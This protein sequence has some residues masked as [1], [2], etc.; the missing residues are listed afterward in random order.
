[1]L[2]Y[3]T[4]YVM[5]L[6]K[7]VFIMNKRV[8]LNLQFACTD[9]YGMPSKNKIKLWVKKIFSIYKKRIELTIRIVE[10]QEI[11]NLNWYFLGKNYPTNVLS[12]PFESQLQICSMFLGDIVICKQ[13][14]QLEAQRHN[15]SSDMY[16]AYIIIHGILHLLGYNHLLDEEAIVM[17]QMELNF[18]KKIGY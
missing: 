9:V 4:L 1:M 14:V 2:V 15:I 3:A 6:H 7:D 13:I 5:V 18:M 11:L 10:V 16:W 17:N 8:I 12:F